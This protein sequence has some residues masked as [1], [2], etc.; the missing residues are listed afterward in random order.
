MSETVATIDD[1]KKISETTGFSYDIIAVIHRNVAKNTNTSEL[2]YFLNVCKGVG[3]NP[4]NKEIWCYK[5]NKDNLLVFTGRDGFLKKAQEH[6]RYNGIRSCEVRK[7]D[8][9]KIDV[10][11]NRITH[12]FNTEDRG[13]L[14]GAYAIVFLKGGEPTIEWAPMRTYDKGNFTWKSH[15]EEMIKKVAECHA[16]KKCFGMTGLQAD[17]DWNINEQ[18]VASPVSIVDEGDSRESKEEERLLK[19]IQNSPSRLK[20]SALKNDCL[21]E[22]TISAYDK[23]WSELPVI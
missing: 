23:K 11:N 6:K 8:N 21:S 14:I 16:L 13:N 20:L 17:V 12:E 18:G 1:Y 10:A 5:D 9:F 22:A 15:P 7:N 3:L 2:V 4:F 19:L